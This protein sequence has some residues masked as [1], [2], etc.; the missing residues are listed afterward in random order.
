MRKKII[1]LLLSFALI[2]CGTSFAAAASGEILSVAVKENTSII[3]ITMDA[4]FTGTM[5][6]KIYSGTQLVGRGSF[7]V[8]NEKT[9]QYRIPMTAL[10]RGDNTVV[11]TPINDK[12]DS[13]PSKAITVYSGIDTASETGMQDV[14]LNTPACSRAV[15]I[16]Y[17]SVYSDVSMTKEIAKL[18]RHDI[19][20]VLKAS[21]F[22]AKVIFDMDTM[23]QSVDD[24]TQVNRIGYIRTS[25]LTLQDGIKYEAD[26]QREVIELAMTRLGNKG[27]YSQP[28]RFKGYY[29]DCSAFVLFCYYNIG[30]DFEWSTCTG[31]ANWANSHRQAVLVWQATPTREITAKAIEEF[32]VAHDMPL[33][34]PLFFDNNNERYDGEYALLNEERIL[35][36]ESNLRD[37]VMSKLQPGDVLLCNHKV[38]VV[39]TSTK[40][41]LGRY[42]QNETPLG[43][44]YDHVM[45]FVKY[46]GD[47]V[48]TV[49]H[50]AGTRT[51]TVIDEISQY[52]ND[53]YLVLR[54]VGIFQENTQP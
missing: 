19:V 39:E 52:D 15:M 8:E 37:D 42:C 7:E 21:E 1:S 11:F 9:I 43:Y 35:T 28:N 36:Y 14:I 29:T 33:E 6:F 10:V 47:G 46:N 24:A 45:L 50:A 48:I 40:E 2:I 31:I 49:I 23:T 44:G 20:F 4:P 34:E 3:E 13:A 41:I 30:V 25:A 27:L 12:G 16:P 17:A 54:P 22:V 51:N 38:P 26:K 5:V 53:I 18:K 32:K